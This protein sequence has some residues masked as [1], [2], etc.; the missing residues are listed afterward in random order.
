MKWYKFK[1]WIIAMLG[2]ILSMLFWS[3]VIQI[4]SPCDEYKTNS[5]DMI[6]IYQSQRNIK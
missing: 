1:I 2:I 6:N 5:Q 4:Y 3:T